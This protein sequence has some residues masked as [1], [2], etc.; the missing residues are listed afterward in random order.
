MIL[1]EEDVTLTTSTG[2]M[3]TV[4]F[5]PVAEG[6]YPGLVLFSEIFQITGPIRR[7]AALLAGHGF[8]VAVPEIFHNLEKAGCVLAYDQE[9]AD[10]GNQDKFAKS[11]A[12]YDEDAR[13]VIGYLSTLP[14]CS[15]KLGAVGICIGGHLSFRAAMNPEVQAAVCYYATDIHSGTLGEG[16]CDN[17]LQRIG[18]IQGELL[19]F[20]GRQDPHVPQEGRTR[21]HEA[22]TRAGT[23]FT[24]HEYN[25]QHAFLR[26][27]GHRYD[28]ELAL[29]TY[30]MTTRFF[31]RTLGTA[32]RF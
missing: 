18:E 6:S 15:G 26:D 24:W 23:I 22:L 10:R 8:I 20:W 27:E 32:A 11:I 13:V 7:T 14:G 21:I 5:R 16:K 4:V 1:K 2:P 25:A 12:S 19:M 28:P 30:G 3:R 31:Q 29:E 9:G 17:S